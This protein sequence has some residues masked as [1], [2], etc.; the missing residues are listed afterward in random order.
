MGNRFCFSA[1]RKKK[2]KEEWGNKEMSGGDVLIM[3][4]DWVKKIDENGFLQREK[5]WISF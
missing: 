2:R 3:S 1:K 4:S 5:K